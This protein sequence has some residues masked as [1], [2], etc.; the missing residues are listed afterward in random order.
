MKILMGLHSFGILMWMGGLIT[1][2]RLLILHPKESLLVR[3]RFIYLESGFLKFTA[4]PGICITAISGLFLLYSSVGFNFSLYPSELILKLYLYIS[5]AIIHALVVI[6]F[7]IFSQHAINEQ[8]DV[9]VF[10]I[11][12][13]ALL[14]ITIIVLIL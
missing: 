9:T 2:L 4:L 11:E 6:Q 14:L 10:M 5:M 7:R 12:H 13:K 1:A 3:P 8:N